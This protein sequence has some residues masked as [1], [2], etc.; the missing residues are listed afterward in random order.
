MD[1]SMLQREYVLNATSKSILWTAISTP[2]GLEG[3]FADRVLANGKMLTFCWG[4]AER[5]EAEILAS[6]VQSYI[7]FRWLDSSSEREYFELRMLCSELTND[8]VLEVIDFAPSSE[9]DDLSELW[10]TQVE[11]L[12]RTCGF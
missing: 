7:R 11:T 3:W 2:I 12:R 5:R 1:K 6:R 9:V 8:V 4:K 10:D